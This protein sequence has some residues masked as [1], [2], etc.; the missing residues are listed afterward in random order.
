MASSMDANF[1]RQIGRTN[2]VGGTNK[3]HT[4]ARDCYRVPYFECCWS[5]FPYESWSAKNNDRESEK[6]VTNKMQKQETRRNK[7]KHGDKN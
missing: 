7:K 1:R 3:E 6:E 4:L 5:S 2:K